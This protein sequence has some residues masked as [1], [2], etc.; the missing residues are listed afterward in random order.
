[1]IGFLS[2]KPKSTSLLAAAF[3]LLGHLTPVVIGLK[4]T[5]GSPCANVCNKVS[6]NTTASEIVCLDQQFSQ[7]TKGSDFQNCV[8][9]QLQSTYSNSSSGETDV[10]WGLYNLRYAFSSCVYGFPE[11]VANISSP[12]V[13][14][15]QPLS[16]ALE[17]DLD[18]PNGVNFDTWCGASSFADNLISQCEFCYNLTSNMTDSQVYLANFLEALRYNC[19]FRTPTSKAFPISPSR[20]FSESMLPQSTVDLTSPSANA[21]SGSS[22]L[23]LIIALPILGFVILI[24]ILAVGCFFF[25]RWRRKQARKNRRSDHLHARWND[26]TISTP[27]HGAWAD[28]AKNGMYSQPMHHPGSGHGFNFVDTDG[29]TQ[30]VGFSK[31]NYVEITESPVTVPSTTH[32]PEQ[33]KGYH[34]QT[35]FPER[36]GSP[37]QKQ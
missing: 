12:C 4:T 22:H 8:D 9:C 15:C 37:P 10:G 1:M 32:S 16:S 19:H 33:E 28:P 21:N 31:S 30:E 11:Q 6:S 36:S 29:R 2:Q 23:A 17:Y 20:V 26:T 35:Y 25:I 18:H 3:L 34:A 24:C 5:P 27:A 7:T 13:V 14:S